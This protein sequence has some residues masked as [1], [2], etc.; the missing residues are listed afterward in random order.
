MFA[1][2][3][4]LAN[5]V[6]L[7]DANGLQGFG[8]T[9]EIASLEPIGTKFARLGLHVEEINGHDPAA[10]DA[11]LR[12]PRDA[13]LVVVLRTVKGRGVSFMEGQDGMALSRND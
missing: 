11:V 13:P 2:H 9:T 4:K 1:R 3:Q 5:L 8:S 6:T 12:A 10:L 7:V